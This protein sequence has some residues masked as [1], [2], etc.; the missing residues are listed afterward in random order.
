MELAVKIFSMGLNPK[1]IGYKKTVDIYIP[2]ISPQR[3]YCS[4][5]MRTSKRESFARTSHRSFPTACVVSPDLEDAGISTSLFDDFS[6][7]ATNTNA[8]EIKMRIDVSGAKTQAIFDDVFSKMVA[9][10]Q[11]IP[12][13]R[14]VKGGKTPDIPKDI[15]LHVLGPSKVY[16]QVIKKIINSAIS[17]YVEKEGLKV[18]KDLRVDQSF[19]ELEAS[20]EPGEEFGFDATIQLQKQN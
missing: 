5:W 7:S 6:I 17:D 1:T 4:L 11:P 10:A 9:A 19:E 8:R 12:G 16:M 15:L 13:F 2:E 18:G 14:R 3:T 20:F